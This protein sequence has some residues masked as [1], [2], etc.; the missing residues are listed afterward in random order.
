VRHRLQKDGT[1]DRAVGTPQDE[2]WKRKR[3]QKGLKMTCCRDKTC[4]S[5]EYTHD[6]ETESE[7][8]EKN[9]VSK[10]AIRLRK[11]EKIGKPLVSCMVERIKKVNDRFQ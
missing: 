4:A 8:I 11:R 5:W 3:S 2:R 1:Q 10:V 6:A 9:M 7:A